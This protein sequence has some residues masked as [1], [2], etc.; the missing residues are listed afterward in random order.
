MLIAEVA[1]NAQMN[2]FNGNAIPFAHEIW[3][4]AH[5]GTIQKKIETCKTFLLLDSLEKA[6][7]KKK[8]AT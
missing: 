2:E 7:Q 8:N 4:V 6:H 1:L 5:L 3:V